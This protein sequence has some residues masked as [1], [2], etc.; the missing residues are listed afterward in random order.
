MIQIVLVKLIKTRYK[1]FSL[2]LYCFDIFYNFFYQNII[3]TLYEKV[4]F[5]W[6]ASLNSVFFDQFLIRN[7]ISQPWVEVPPELA[8]N[9]FVL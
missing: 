4:S 9:A 1:F 5:F 6:F 8:L 2:L 7:T 3:I